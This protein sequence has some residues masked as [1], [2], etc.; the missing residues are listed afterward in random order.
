MRK[1]I[2]SFGR[3][4][5]L[6]FDD[7]REEFI[8]AVEENDFV[9]L[10]GDTG[11]GK[12]L[13]GPVAL[14][15]AFPEAKIAVTQPRRNAVSSLAK[16][17]AFEQGWKLGDEHVGYYLARQKSPM[18]KKTK[19]VFQID[20][21]LVNRVL[22]NGAL[23]EYDIVFLDEQHL[24]TVP[25]DIL[26]GRLSA[27][28][29]KRPDFKV[30]IST[31]TPNITKLEDFYGQFG[32]VSTVRVEGRPGKVDIRWAWMH[33]REHH[34]DAVKRWMEVLVEEGCRGK[35]AVFLPGVEEINEVINFVE[36]LQQPDIDALPCHGKLDDDEQDRIYE[37]VSGNRL[38][39]IVATEII[40][41][42]ITIPDL[43]GGIDSM[44]VF[45]KDLNWMG[46]ASYVKRNIAKD[47][48]K[49]RMGRFGRIEGTTGFYMPIIGFE[50]DES[51][52]RHWNQLVEHTQPQIL[53]TDI[54]S[55]VLTVE[56][57]GIEF[58]K[59][60]WMDRPSLDDY[61]KTVIN[62]QRLGALDE[63]G[64]I[65]EEGKIY[66]RMP[67]SAGLAKAILKAQEFG[68]AKFVK[69]GAA[70]LQDNDSI[71]FV[72]G[73]RKDLELTPAMEKLLPKEARESVRSKTRIIRTKKREREIEI[74]YLPSSSSWNGQRL[75]KYHRE[76]FAAGTNS[77]IVAI[78]IAY[79]LWQE[80]GRSAQWARARML[81]SK[82]LWNMFNSIRDID[83][84]LREAGINGKKEAEAETVNPQLVV[85][86]LAAGLVNNLAVHEEKNNY[87]G[88]LYNLIVSSTSAINNAKKR[89]KV[90]LFSNVTLAK[91]IG[92][93]G[94]DLRFAEIL[95]EINPEDIATDNPQLCKYLYDEYEY[96]PERDIVEADE[97][98]KYV[99]TEIRVQKVV[100]GSNDNQAIQAFAT[101]LA[102]GKVEYPGKADNDALVA[103]IDVLN[104]R[105]QGSIGQITSGK[106][107]EIFQVRL[108][109]V[110]AC[111]LQEA[112]EKGV[113]FSISDAD[114]E[115]VLLV[116]SL[117]DIR[118][119]TPVERPDVWTIDGQ[120]FS[121]EYKL[122]SW[123]YTGAILWLSVSVAKKVKLA[124]LP[125]FGENCKVRVAV[126]EEGY[127]DVYVDSKIEK[128][129]E[130]IEVRRLELA[131]ESFI[132]QEGY[133]DYDNQIKVLYPEDFPAMPDP[134]IWDQNTGSLAYAV[135]V[136]QWQSRECD[137]VYTQWY[138]RWFK[139]SE[140]DDA[141]EK[142]KKAKEEADTAEF[143]RQNFDRLKQE[144]QELFVKVKEL[145]EQIDW[146]NHETYNLT[147]D[148]TSYYNGLRQELSTAENFVGLTGY[149]A[150]PTRALKILNKLKNRFE[151]AIATFE[152][153]E[154]LKREVEERRQA[155]IDAGE[156]WPDVAV[157][158]SGR[159]REQTTAFCVAPDGSIIEPKGSE[160]NYGDLPTTHLVL[161][162][163]ISTYS[164]MYSEKW[165]VV[166]FPKEITVE[167]RQAVASLGEK[168]PRRFFQGEGTGWNLKTGEE[169][170]FT[171][172]YS[173]DMKGNDRTAHDEQRENF[174]IN[175]SEYKSWI[176]KDPYGGVWSIPEY[177]IVIGPHKKCR[178]KSQN[179]SEPK[180]I[181]S[182][183]G[184]SGFNNP[185]AVLAS[186]KK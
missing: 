135:P 114:A 179:I 125:D 25:V 62:L 134:V 88:I 136:Y 76:Q 43:V 112:K 101:A 14:H 59:F 50:S 72:P 181:V 100:R 29:E 158:I 28:R 1:D 170:F 128:L 34:L 180:P 166:R 177:A 150:Q 164:Y 141:W 35:V 6:P 139:S 92:W 57:M 115:S 55:A 23:S 36:S 96:N 103:E 31:A 182:V 120:E 145:S 37:P 172:S 39:F 162:H 151:S 148:E 66:A 133:G 80:N 47:S 184:E 85:R 165:E 175:V 33:K 153:Q 111:T 167:Q 32:S 110:N 42:S 171:T 173:R 67:F 21:S 75:A 53:A 4:G 168:L 9:I 129:A 83:Q 17:I 144:A 97:H 81:K 87:S 70:G 142:A 118:K 58:D 99:N 93:R 98:L 13:R 119:R 176:G 38:R 12:T 152:E 78:I 159:S 143:E 186:L 146:N 15:K 51:A 52:E 105:W 22:E 45:R 117:A 154:R 106:L 60:P 49:Q 131:W 130:K 71:F 63:N 183:G 89:P 138:I 121:I 163:E 18:T 95:S 109:E 48:A 5:H 54:E 74:R 65:T 161:S 108:E 156:L 68:V 7:R 107:S 147:S 64:R 26:Q 56:A 94:S 77:D 127:S 104:I 169:V 27:I 185:F 44:Q 116:D 137:D 178:K 11:S 113:D 79:L 24:R 84:A 102:S 2:S 82:V 8:Q 149:R 90:V 140:K 132:S 91:G 157:P 73:R 40:E 46:V 160:G 122:S 155:L 41:T 123:M 16:R 30:I 126:L 174:P 86:A 61:K 20:Q 69:I 10:Y 124:D 3:P 19:I